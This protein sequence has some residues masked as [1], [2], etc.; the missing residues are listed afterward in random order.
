MKI[1][2]LLFLYYTIINT[3]N[4][5]STY[6]EINNVNSSKENIKLHNPPSPMPSSPPPPPCCDYPPPAPQVIQQEAP[7]NNAPI[8]NVPINNVPINNVPIPIPS[9]PIYL[10][11]TCQFM[12]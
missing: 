4:S 10:T 2:Q 3:V 1:I 5:Q 12:F 9:P 7:I 11:P 8:N 6:K